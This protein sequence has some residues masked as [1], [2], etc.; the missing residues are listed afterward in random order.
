MKRNFLM[1]WHSPN[2]TGESVSRCQ[3]QPTPFPQFCAC[4][5][6]SLKGISAKSLKI[7][8]FSV[9]VSILGGGQID[10]SEGGLKD[11]RNQTHSRKTKQAVALMI[12]TTVSVCADAHLIKP[13][14]LQA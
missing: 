2:N 12:R 5:T 10:G 11:P 7:K 4:V 9:H 14:Q 3:K 1:P 8:V 13:L 6:P